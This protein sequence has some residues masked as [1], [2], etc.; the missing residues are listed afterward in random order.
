MATKEEITKRIQD[1]I[2]LCDEVRSKIKTDLNNG[3]NQKEN[4]ENLFLQQNKIF[5][6]L[7]TFKN[8]MKNE[9]L[10]GLSS[11]M[12]FLES[13]REKIEAKELPISLDESVETQ[14][15]Q[16][17]GTLEAYKIG[18]SLMDLTK[19][20]TYGF[21]LLQLLGLIGSAGLLL[22]LLYQLLT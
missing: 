14:Q 3:L 17:F 18:G 22:T 4:I 10:N 20:Y 8:A 19:Y 5:I 9:R 16:Q 11:S 7:E 13:V 2:N 21:S 6:S 1:A 12:A 15:P